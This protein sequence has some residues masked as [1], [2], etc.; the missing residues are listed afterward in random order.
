LLPTSDAVGNPVASIRG[1]RFAWFA[2]HPDFGV[3]KAVNG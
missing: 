2:F 1:L 3:F